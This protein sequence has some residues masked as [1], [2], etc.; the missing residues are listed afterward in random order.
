MILL[1]ASGLLG[2]AVVKKFEAKGDEG[3]STFRDSEL[4]IAMIVRSTELNV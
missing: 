2:R 3:E 1:G 4:S